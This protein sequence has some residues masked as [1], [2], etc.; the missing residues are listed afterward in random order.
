MTPSLV[1]TL[2]KTTPIIHLVKIL[3]TLRYF[4]TSSFSIYGTPSSN[5]GA[6][7]NN[8]SL[9]QLPLLLPIDQDDAINPFPL[10]INVPANITTATAQSVE[11]YHWSS[12]DDSSLAHKA[13][14]THSGRNCSPSHKTECGYLYDQTACHTSHHK[15]HSLSS[16]HEFTLFSSSIF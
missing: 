12:I 4:H 16:Y 15:C 8:Y 3:F 7:T 9:I 14:S 10:S 5:Q 2:H 1:V 13:S 11:S 6:V